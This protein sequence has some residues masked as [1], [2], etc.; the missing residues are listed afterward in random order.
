MLARCRSWVVAG[1]GTRVVKTAKRGSLRQIE[2]CFEISTMSAC[3]VIAQN[4]SKSGCSIQATGSW[5]R[6]Q[7]QSSQG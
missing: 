3:L 5:R 1:G 7:A 4:G 6:S 2:G